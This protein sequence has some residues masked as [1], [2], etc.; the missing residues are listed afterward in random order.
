MG[1]YPPRGVLAL[2][3]PDW[4]SIPFEAV[5]TRGMTVFFPVFL[6][7]CRDMEWFLSWRWSLVLPGWRWLYQPRVGV[8]KS[9]GTISTWGTTVFVPGLLKL[10]MYGN[11]SDRGMGPYPSRM[12]LAL[13]TPSWGFHPLRGGMESG[14]HR[15]RTVL[16]Q[17]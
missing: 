6:L 13:R 1:P 11:I 17:L 4:V 12:A 10:Y 3:T 2:R 9:C 16:F 8:S 5:S 7:D 14:D 15:F